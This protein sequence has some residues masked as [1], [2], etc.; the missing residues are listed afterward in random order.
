MFISVTYYPDR[1][2]LTAHNLEPERPLCRSKV[3]TLPADN[4][5][6]RIVWN[7]KPLNLICW[8]ARLRHSGCILQRALSK[9]PHAHTH[10]HIHTPHTWYLSV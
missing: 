6:W 2:M 5:K 1:L 3:S 8:S 4:T 7:S 10:T 9:Q